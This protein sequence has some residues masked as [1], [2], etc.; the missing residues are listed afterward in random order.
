MGDPTGFV[1]FPKRLRRFH[2]RFSNMKG[3][4]G[5]FEGRFEVFQARY[6]RLSVPF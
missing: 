5:R 2:E 6:K 4:S 3:V 1:D